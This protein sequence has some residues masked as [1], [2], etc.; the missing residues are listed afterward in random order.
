MSAKYLV[1]TSKNQNVYFGH[2]PGLAATFYERELRRP[3]VT[4]A[5]LFRQDG[6]DRKILKAAGPDVRIDTEVVCDKCRRRHYVSRIACEQVGW[7]TCCYPGPM[8]PVSQ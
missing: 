8:R 3:D 1:S 2:D 7:P 4:S 5:V 6:P